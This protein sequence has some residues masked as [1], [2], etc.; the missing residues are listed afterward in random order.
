M[1]MASMG[2]R[3]GAG[4]TRGSGPRLSTAAEKPLHAPSGR[5]RAETARARAATPASAAG[6]ALGEEWSSAHGLGYHHPRDDPAAIFFMPE[7]SLQGPGCVGLFARRLAEAGVRRALLVTSGPGGAMIAPG[8]PVS[9]VAA[10]LEG[11]GVDSVVFDRVMPNPTAAVVD[12]GVEFYEAQG[13]DCIV[14]VGGGSP[15][16]AAKGIAIVAT[17][18]G[19][20]QRYEGVDRVPGKLVPLYAVNT[21]AGTASEMTRFT[22]ITDTERKV[23]MAIVD[24]KCTPLA[25][26]NDPLMHV[27]MPKGLTA[28]T[29]MDAL[30]HAIEAYV[31]NASNPL[32]DACSLHAI[33]LINRYLKDAQQDGRDLEAREFMA[34]S[35]FLAGMAFN[36]AGLGFV[37]AIAHQLGGFYN[38]PHGVCNAVLLPTVEAWNARAV[39]GLF[40]DLARAF[41]FAVGDDEADR[42]VRLVLGR[43]AEMNAELGIPRNLAELGVDPADFEVLAANA[44]KDACAT[45]NPVPYSHSEVVQILAEAYGEE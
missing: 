16:D 44:L 42:A 30:T 34:Y 13:C 17:H 4:R 5:G 12:E 25:A 32:T 26:V 37:H 40:I 24:A 6:D 23:K 39:P 9:V 43:I 14:S 20:I 29:G 22:I 41:D 27:G 18:G 21:T 45:N 33:R 15:H 2:R 38:L 36:N 7:A 1:S 19:P 31:S 10:E 35:E 3:T 11:A 28:A 8:G